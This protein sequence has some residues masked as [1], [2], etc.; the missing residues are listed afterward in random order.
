MNEYYYERAQN[1]RYARVTAKRRSIIFRRRL[2]MVILFLAISIT[3][4][5]SIRF[6]AYADSKN[7]LRV[8]KYRS[9]LIYCKDT[10]DSIA[11][12]YLDYGYNSKS[13]FVKEVCSIN[14]ITTNTVLIAGN[15]LILP[16]FDD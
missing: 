4:V 1:R 8:K 6:F 10:L 5:F 11:D 3:A 2:L 12:N 7:D 16:Y 9:E 15:H 13:R 14:S